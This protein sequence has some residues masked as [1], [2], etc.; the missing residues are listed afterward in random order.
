VDEEEDADGEHEDE[1][2]N[3]EPKM[4]M[5]IPHLVGESHRLKQ[6]ESFMQRSFHDDDDFVPEGF[7]LRADIKG[8]LAF[9]L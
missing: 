4:E 1:R 2:A 3:E 5:K 6:R 8:E 9:L 7:V